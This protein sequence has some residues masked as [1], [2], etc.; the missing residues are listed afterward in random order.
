MATAFGWND[1]RKLSKERLYIYIY[2]CPV[3]KHI[4][5]QHDN[6]IQKHDNDDDELKKLINNSLYSLKMFQIRS[7]EIS[8][9]PYCFYNILS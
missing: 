1:L 3:Y 9:L 8:E 2:V 7:M 5:S 6:N 4:L